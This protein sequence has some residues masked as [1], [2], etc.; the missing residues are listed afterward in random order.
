M[1]WHHRIFNLFR[2]DDLDREIQKEMEFHIAERIDELVA[3]GTTQKEAER[4]AR[5]QFGKQR[6]AEGKDARYGR[7]WLR[8]STRQLDR[9]LNFSEA[10]YP[11]PFYRF[12]ER[13]RVFRFFGRVLSMK[14]SSRDCQASLR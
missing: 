10:D 6:F 7:C 14:M 13:G 12:T 8:P 4:I 5:R 3:S 9:N 1:A 2:T 11:F